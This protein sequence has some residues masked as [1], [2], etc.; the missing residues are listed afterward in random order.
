MIAVTGFIAVALIAM[1]LAPQT[2]FGQLCHRQLV[3]RPAHRLLNLQRKDILYGLILLG[4]MLGGGELA[5]LL[6]PEFMAAYAMDMA[7]YFDAVLVSY[8]ATLAAKLRG[9]RVAVLAA[10]GRPFRRSAPRRKRNAS[11]PSAARKPAN[12]DEPH[13]ARLAA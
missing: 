7:I 1:L 4:V 6:G 8:A 9:A 10:I 11:T 3:E 13:P 5:W 2:E 12:D